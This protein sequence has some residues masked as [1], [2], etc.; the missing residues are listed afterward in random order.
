MSATLVLK[1]L[2]IACLPCNDHDRPT[3]LHAC[4]GPAG[5]AAL[6]NELL[7][8]LAN[9]SAWSLAP[10]SRRLLLLGLVALVG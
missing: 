6:E 10:P 4:T 5:A 7:D 8:T 2:S 3:L 1:P 9:S